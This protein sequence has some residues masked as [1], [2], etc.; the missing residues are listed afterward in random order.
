L[1]KKERWRPKA[2]RWESAWGAGRGKYGVNWSFS[3][4]I[5]VPT[6]VGPDKAGPFRLGRGGL[7]PSAVIIRYI[8][9]LLDYPDALRRDILGVYQPRNV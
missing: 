5:S 1:E 9:S 3:E 4:T 2:R 8:L 6:F 7:R